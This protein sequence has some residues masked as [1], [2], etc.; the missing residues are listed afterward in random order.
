MGKI[1]VQ[2]IANKL[3]AQNGLSKKEATLFV[4]MMFDLIRE[5]VER[6]KSVKIKGLGT[7]KIIDVD[8]RESVNVNTGERVLIEGHNKITFTPDA[9]M[10][11]L[12]NKPFSQFETIVLNDGVDFKD[13]GNDEEDSK[14]EVS[15]LDESDSEI[16]EMPLV[17]FAS[18]EPVDVKPIILGTPKEP[19]TLVE[20]E[21]PKEPELTAV[22]E[23][24]VEPEVSVEPESTVEP[25]LSVEPEVSAE[26]SVE[27]E[28]PSGQE[29]PS[30]PEPSVEAEAPAGQETPADPEEA[31]E[32]GADIEE[33]VS[34]EDE[35]PADKRWMLWLL[36]CLLALGTGYLLGNYFP[37]QRQTENMETVSPQADNDVP[38]KPVAQP[39]EPV[40]KPVEPIEEKAEAPKETEA[41]KEVV[42]TEA[43]KQPDAAPQK[44]P[45]A[46]PQKQ[47]EAKPQRQPEARPQKQLEAKPAEVKAPAKAPE[48]K[49]DKYEMKDSRV[50]NGAYRIVG[51][52]FVLKV[53][54]GDNLQ[55]ICKRTLGAGMECYIEVYNNINASTQLKKGMEIKIPK[56]EWKKKKTAKK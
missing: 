3:I 50:K 35:E 12:V 51:T 16:G 53:K 47:L 8:S 56:V 25:K 7:F 10:K 15:D 55:R 22:L 39:A 2:E 1:T 41:E 24:T 26:P 23:S 36:A 18:G 34:L 4:N 32:E 17:D 14:A 9:L 20:P 28:A 43:K 38:A 54:E 42:E 48:V 40:A 5:I 27:A 49:L 33:F 46:K 30:E 37:F 19:E 13:A 31:V 6:D 21:V 52:D 11:E 44:Q 29:T 45:E